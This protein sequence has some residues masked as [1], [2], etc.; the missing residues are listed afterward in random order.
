MTTGIYSFINKET[1][2][3]YIGQAADIEKR[4]EQHLRELRN[5]NH[6]SD[7]FQKAFNK[8]GEK[9]FEFEILEEC[10]TD[11]LNHLEDYYVKLFDSIDNGYNVALTCLSVYENGKEN[12]NLRTQR[13][14][15]K[16]ISNKKTKKDATGSVQVKSG[17]Y[18]LVIRCGENEERKSKWM[19]TGLEVKGNKLKAEKMLIEKLEELNKPEEDKLLFSDFIEEWLKIIQHSVKE[20]TF[21]N[22]QNLVINQISPYFKE[23]GILLKDL[24]T[25]DIQN[26]YNFKMQTV[27]S[28]TI[29]KHHA[30]IHKALKYAVQTNLII[31]NPA[32]FVCKPKKYRAKTSYYTE[33]QLNKL[34][35]AV[36]GT[37][38]ETPVLLAGYYGLRRSEVLGLKWKAIDFDNN[39][40]SIEHT[41]TRAKGKTLCLDDTKSKSSYRILPLV[42]NLKPYLLDL[43]SKHKEMFDNDTEYVCR[44]DDG[45]LLSPDYITET[46]KKILLQNDLPE[47]RFHDLRH[48]SAS[49]LLK[50]GFTLKE[51]QEW[52]GHSDIN[53]TAMYYSHLQ[54][55]SKVNM[56]NKVNSKLKIAM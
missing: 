32:E 50:L 16:K 34:F 53:V 4:K 29:Y 2:K 14:K 43:K 52:L 27:S 7:K 22:Y 47:I 3:R 30:N 42:D 46:F 38:M 10:C 9:S 41:V 23:K 21:Y 55:S 54:Y 44:Y 6:H 24:T 51:I 19:P 33:D 1:G 18:Y 20:N 45:R 37:Q 56:A 35:E 39:T 11:K 13:K 28:S 26:Y 36:K 5:R 17:R 31:K 15:Y 49:M 25:N 40:I 12:I 48:S 8:Y